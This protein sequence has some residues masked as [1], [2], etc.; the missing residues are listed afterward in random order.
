MKQLLEERLINGDFAMGELG[1]QFEV[2]GNAHGTASVEREGPDGTPSLKVTVQEISESDAW[3][4]QV[5]Q[6]GINFTKGNSY[7]MSFWGRADSNVQIKLNF[8]QDHEPGEHHAAQQEIRLNSTWQKFEYDFVGPYDDSEMKVQFTD[9]ATK[10]GQTYWFS[11][12]SLLEGT[13]Q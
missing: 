11:N 8:Q 10:I 4:L 3:H 9:L 5:A 1:W 13:A 6:K 12:C 7:V 2:N